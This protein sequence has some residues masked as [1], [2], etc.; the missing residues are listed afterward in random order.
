MKISSNNYSYAVYKHVEWKKEKKNLLTIQFIESILKMSFLQSH[1]E[2]QRVWYLLQKQTNKKNPIM[3]Q[4][5]PYVMLKK[6][7]VILE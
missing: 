4:E 3:A 2:V 7:S 5:Q 6:E 1:K